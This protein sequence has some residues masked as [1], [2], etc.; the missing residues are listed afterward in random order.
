VIRTKP[1]SSA[2]PYRSYL[3]FR[4]ASLLCLERF[5]VVVQIRYSLLN[6]TLMS[7]AHVPEEWSPDRHILASMGW[8]VYFVYI[9]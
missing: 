8:Q 4:C 1:G 9:S 6:F 7:L 3:R 5:D 2:A